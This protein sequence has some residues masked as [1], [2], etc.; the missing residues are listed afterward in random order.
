MSAFFGLKILEF[1]VIRLK[2]FSALAQKI[3]P[4]LHFERFRERLT[5]KRV[6]RY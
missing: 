4:E 3:N 1:F 2:S 5:S 6:V